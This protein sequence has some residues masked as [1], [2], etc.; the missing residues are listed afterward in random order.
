MARKKEPGPAGFVLF[1][2][3]YEDGTQSSNRKVPDSEVGGLDGDL[4][5][6]TFIEQQDRMVGEK[7]GRPRGKIKT[8]VRSGR[9]LLPQAQSG[10]A[11]ARSRG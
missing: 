4:P 6:K 2:V 3:V 10:Y 9:R 1:D 8:L 5:A 7:S 11:A